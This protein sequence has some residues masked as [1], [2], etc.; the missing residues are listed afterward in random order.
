MK[1]FRVV[2]ERDG[3]TTKEPGR[4]TTGIVREEFRYAATTIKDVWDAITWLHNDPERTLIALIEDAPSIT[5]LTPIEEQH[6]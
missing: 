4:V 1:I 2:T 3:Q 6:D 5:V